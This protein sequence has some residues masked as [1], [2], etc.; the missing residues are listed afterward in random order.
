MQVQGY[1][2]ISSGSRGTKKETYGAIWCV[3]VFFSP[4]S[5]LFPPLLLA[6]LSL[7]SLL[8]FLLL[9]VHSKLI[10]YAG[11]LRAMSP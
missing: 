8:S 9:P 4:F 5:L 10:Q 2:R 3:L 11:G 1:Y 7:L 6:L